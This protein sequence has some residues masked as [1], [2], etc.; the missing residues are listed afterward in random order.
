MNFFPLFLIFLRF[1]LKKN[2]FFPIT[3][4]LRTSTERFLV[5]TLYKL[6]I[7]FYFPYIFVPRFIKFTLR[8]Q[9]SRVFG[10]FFPI[11][12]IFLRFVLKKNYFFV[13]RFEFKSEKVTFF[14]YFLYFFL[15][16]WFFLRFVLKKVVFLNFFLLFLIFLRFVLKEIIFSL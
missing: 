7:F 4:N 14:L 2:Y 8:F 9:K 1:V 10:I 12:L 5:L 15:Y 6:P 13:L 3:P 16:F 11:F